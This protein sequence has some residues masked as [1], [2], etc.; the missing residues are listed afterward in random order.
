MASKPKKLC[1]APGCVELT[2]EAYCE[3]H[4]LERLREADSRR[5]SSTKRGYDSRWKKYRFIFLQK[6]PLCVSCKDQGRLTTATVVDHITPHKGDMRLFWDPK[7]HQ[8]LCK[9]CHDRKT[10]SE[11]DG[12]GNKKRRL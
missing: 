6:H 1:N 4:K 12:F 2:T 9:Q 8:A 7:N 5:I 11:D 3:K 10:A